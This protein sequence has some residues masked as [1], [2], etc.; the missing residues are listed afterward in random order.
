MRHL[1]SI[2]QLEYLTALAEHRHFGRAAAACHVT[3]STLSAGIRDLEGVLGIPLAERSKRHVMMTAPGLEIAGRAR[4]LIRDAEDMMDLA[5]AHQG[6]GPGQLA[7]ELRLG[8]IPTIGPYLLPEM[9]QGLRRDYPDLKLLLRE[10]QT[11]VLLGRL[12]DGTLD[13]AILALPYYLGGLVSMTLFADGF[14]LA[15]PPGHPLAGQAAVTHDDLQDQEL[16]LLEDGHCLRGHA[17]AACHLSENH[18]QSSFEATSLTTLVQM[19]AAGIG[20]T[21]LPDMA[22]QTGITRGTDIQLVP[23]AGDDAAR[24][25]GLVW[26]R[27][28]P[29]AEAF[30]RLGMKVISDRAPR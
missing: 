11:E 20:I 3:P 23:V 19:V 17:L 4:N 13:A 1:P 8:V 29:R 27:S 16:L 21:M 7:G 26:R 12:R 24:D 28:S 6:G 15:C 2:K 10:E 9:M 30:R 14:H 22:V 18:L 5:R 25:I